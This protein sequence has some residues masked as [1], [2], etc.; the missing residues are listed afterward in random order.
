MLSEAGCDSETRI[1]AFVFLPI[2]QECKALKPPSAANPPETRFVCAKP[3]W[4]TCPRNC[5]ATILPGCTGKHSSKPS[6][7]YSHL[8][9]L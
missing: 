9:N 3:P 7:K 5:Y 1:E 8:H 2:R 6:W 4:G